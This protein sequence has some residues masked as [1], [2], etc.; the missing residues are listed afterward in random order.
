MSKFG[1]KKFS[2]SLNLTLIIMHLAHSEIHITY[3]VLAKG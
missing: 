3:T 2:A 1:V